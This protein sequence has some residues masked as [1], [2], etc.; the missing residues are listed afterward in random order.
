[1]LFISCSTSATL[2]T[3]TF[4]RSSRFKK[5]MTKTK[6]TAMGLI[7]GSS[8]MMV[9]GSFKDGH[10]IVGETG[11]YAVLQGLLLEL[12][13]KRELSVRRG[14]MKSIDK[15][16]RFWWTFSTRSRLRILWRTTRLMI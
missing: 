16:A 11:L 13:V 1:M 15:I 6:G 12:K 5:S 4:P 14:C 8:A 9:E 2:G 7:E 3:P 10:G